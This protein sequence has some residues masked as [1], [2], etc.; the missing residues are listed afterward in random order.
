MTPDQMFLAGVA[1][2]CLVTFGLC[3]GYLEAGAWFWNLAI[4][5]TKRA[6]RAAERP[7]VWIEQKKP[8]VRSGAS[9]GVVVRV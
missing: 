1:V 6:E 8:R 4:D 3:R 2:G 5:E 9:V 7:V